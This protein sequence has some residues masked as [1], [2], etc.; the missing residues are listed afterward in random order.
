MQK[1]KYVLLIFFYCLFDST[2]FLFEK[3]I[4][5]YHFNKLC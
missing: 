1:L 4:Y 5:L 2:A 3:N